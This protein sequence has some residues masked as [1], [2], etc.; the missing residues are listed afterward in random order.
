MS[1]I[2]LVNIASKFEENIIIGGSAKKCSSK[3]GSSDFSGP[4]QL[5]YFCEKNLKGTFIVNIL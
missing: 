1:D 3:K 2:F 5:F 4:N